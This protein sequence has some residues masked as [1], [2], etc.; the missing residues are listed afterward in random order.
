MFKRKPGE[1]TLNINERSVRVDLAE[2]FV[3]GGVE[4][5]FD[6]E[7]QITTR[8]LTTEGFVTEVKAFIDAVDR[9]FSPSNGMFKA[10]CE[11]LAQGVA[12]VA[13]KN[14]KN[15]VECYVEVKNLTGSVIFTWKKGNKVPTFP[16]RAKTYARKVRSQ[17]SSPSKC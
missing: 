1:T 13:Y 2:E 7:C 17:S 8:G 5:Y 15:M 16:N 14:T 10:S 4:D 3:C 6:Y 11:E 9:A 12:H